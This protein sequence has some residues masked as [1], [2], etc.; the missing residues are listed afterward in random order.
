MQDWL[1]T[2]MVM[3]FVPVQFVDYVWQTLVNYSKPKITKQ[4]KIDEFLVYFS[5]Q[6]LK[7][8]SLSLEDWNHFDNIGP[9]TNNHV[10]GFNYKLGEYIDYDHPNVYSLIETFKSLE[11]TCIINYLQ[12]KD[13]H[14]IQTRRRKVDISRDVRISNLKLAFNNDH[15]SILDYCRALRL[16]YALND[17]K[18]EE[19]ESKKAGETT[20]EL[21]LTAVNL[22]IDNAFV[23][24]EPQTLSKV[25]ISLQDIRTLAPY[26]W[27]NDTVIDYYFKLL[28]K[29]QPNY[30]SF[31]SY[32]Y[33]SLRQKGVSAAQNWYSKIKIFDLKK[34][35]IPIL[36]NSHWILVVVDIEVS[37]I[38]LYDSFSRNY[39]H[40]LD[41]IHLYLLHMYKFYYNC[42][43]A[44]K[45]QIIH[46][47]S[48][49]LQ[50]NSFDCGMYVC[51]F[52]EFIISQRDFSFGDTDM[53]RYR[54][55]IVLSILRGKIISKF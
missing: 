6:W 53:P 37:S 51:K 35:F 18:E 31:S 52:A 34:I 44:W 45:F 2:F 26:Q 49:P 15:I 28:L 43:L 12:R 20:P 11:M 41:K 39:D 5:R 7:N 54:R 17:T 46:A 19:E 47:R 42:E 13:G 50:N 27:L 40:I 29:D 23:S 36:E 9:R 24:F 25:I 16:L 48:L 8:G 10:E 55:K 22:E 33:T 4:D 1:R 3:P 38:V 30:F 21:D 32:F 14:A